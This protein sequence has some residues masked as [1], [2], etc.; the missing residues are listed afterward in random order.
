MR[1]DDLLASVFPDAAACPENLEGPVRIPDHPLVREVM[2]DALT[3]AMDV[4]G[5]RRVLAHILDGGI[6]CVAV[7]T[8]V[9]SQFSHEI[10]NANPFA[11]LD[12]AP[13]EE[14]RARAVEMRRTLPHKVV[15]E[16]G[17]LDGAA[18]EEIR[19]E[20][21]PDVR[22]AEELHDALQTLI[23]L[24][25]ASTT[26]DSAPA[27]WLDKTVQQSGTDWKSFMEDLVRQGRATRATTATASYWVT[28]ERHKI[29]CQIFPEATF[30]T[31]VADVES[32]VPAADEGL[33]AMVMGWL[34]HSGPVAVSHLADLFGLQSGE[35]D[36][37]MLRLE[38]TGAILRGRFSDPH[39]EDLEWCER[40]L[41]ARIHRATLGK[42]RKEIEPVSASR[43]MR[44]LLRWQHLT[45]DTHLFGEQGTLE[46]LR[47]LQGY[48][49]PA[50]AWER[51]LLARRIAGYDPKILD[52]LCFKGQVGWGRL[53]PCP[54]LVGDLQ[55]VITES[56]LPAPRP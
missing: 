48:E 49:G 28:A 2:K 11:Y 17:R 15:S 43:F 25:E 18:I 46:I 29:F 20:A 51:Q 22:D 12:D 35:V 45:P 42:L 27:N 4:E 16:V 5:L 26:Q 8:P 53:S 13:L 38:A 14:R 30:E 39:S 54:A 47:Q 19:E 7:D 34:Q 50:N 55:Q 31:R 41:L 24:P 52:Q 56:R 36:K 3:E 44:W 37:A 21:W 23:A 1:A 32:S 33:S 10:L 9:P 6:Q 40:R